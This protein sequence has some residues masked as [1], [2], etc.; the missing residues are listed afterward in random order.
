[1]AI[2]P[3]ILQLWRRWA[4]PWPG[5][6][7]EL[8][9]RIERA[10]VMSEASVLLEADLFPERAVHAHA[11]D[12][13]VLPT[14]EVFLLDAERSYLQTALRKAGGRIGIAAGTLGISR[15]TLWDKMRRHKLSGS[16]E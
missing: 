7:R 12:T 9:N 13:G 16:D 6:V 2:A 5:N 8:R 15:K 3:C 14:L 1:M 11:S 4:H 10:C